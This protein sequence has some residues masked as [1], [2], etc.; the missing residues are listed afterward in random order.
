MSTV[1]LSLPDS[2]KTFVDEQ[3]SQRGKERGRQRV[4]ARTAP[5]RSGSAAAAHYAVRGASSAPTASVKETCFVGL[6]ERVRGAAQVARKTRSR[7]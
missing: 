2:L 6:R 5:P 3:V 4:R 7:S 1:N